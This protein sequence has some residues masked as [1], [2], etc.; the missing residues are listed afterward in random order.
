MS[1]GSIIALVMSIIGW[2]VTI[3]IA[4]SEVKRVRK[5][6]YQKGFFDGREDFRSDVRQRIQQEFGESSNVGKWSKTKI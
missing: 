1:K 4:L 3:V 6:E 2:A 5:N